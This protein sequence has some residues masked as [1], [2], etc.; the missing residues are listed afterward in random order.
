MKSQTVGVGGLTWHRLRGNRGSLDLG[1]DGLSVGL[2]EIGR[3]VEPVGPLRLWPDHNINQSVYDC[4]LPGCFWRS[5]AR[6]A[7]HG[8]REFGYVAEGHGSLRNWVLILRGIV[9]INKAMC[10]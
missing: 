1:L 2:G 7:A 4:M 6:P 9:Q 5:V 3:N 8:V 10:W